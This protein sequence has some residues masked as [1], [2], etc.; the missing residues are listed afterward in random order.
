MI[1]DAINILKQKNESTEA[2]LEALLLIV[3]RFEEDYLPIFEGILQ[4]TNE[5]P[6]VRSS[7][8]LALGKISG[9]RPFQIL[10]AYRHDQDATVRN[11]VLRA[12]G[13]THEEDAAPILIEALQDT[14]NTIFATASEALGDLGDKA[15]PYLIELLSTG[16]ED[17]RCVAAWQLGEIGATI[18]VPALIET[19]RTEQRVSVIALCIWALGEIGLGSEEVLQILSEARQQEEPDVRLRAETAIK[20]I[21]RNI[22]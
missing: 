8:A 5:H 16:A 10:Q 13:M 1:E 3:K 11:Y 15:T 4:D 21:V 19:I 2:R 12:L 7:V 9:R 20:K 6:D 18:S 14:N 22:N 17:A